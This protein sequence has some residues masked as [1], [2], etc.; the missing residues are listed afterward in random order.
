MA[1]LF[2][3]VSLILK[4]LVASIPFM[5]KGGRDGGEEEVIFVLRIKQMVFV[6]YIN[7]IIHK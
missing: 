3:A 2:V 5:K 6:L 7:F 1:R 4:Q